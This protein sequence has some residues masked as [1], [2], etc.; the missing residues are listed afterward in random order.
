MKNL[1]TE[2]N[3]A[4]NQSIHQKVRSIVPKLTSDMYKGKNYFICIKLSHASL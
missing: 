2:D 3:Q 1:G 4:E